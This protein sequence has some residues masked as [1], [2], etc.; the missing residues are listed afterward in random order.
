MAPSH[1]TLGGLVMGMCPNDTQNNVQKA[2]WCKNNCTHDLKWLGR[3]MTMSS[4]AS[5]CVVFLLSCAKYFLFYVGNPYT[6]P[7]VI[8]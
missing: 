2:N 1:L 7:V 8:T 5:E 6:D 4:F 3:M